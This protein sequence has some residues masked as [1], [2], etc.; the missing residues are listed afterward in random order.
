VVAVLGGGDAGVVRLLP[1]GDPYLAVCD[2]PLLAPDADHRRALWPRSPWPGAVLADGELAGTWRRQR[3]HVTITPW[4]PTLR[5]TH[6]TTLQAEVTTLPLAAGHPT[7][8]WA[9]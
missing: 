5:R 3:A 4:S 8:T 9:T 7:L 1:P 6:A 2:K